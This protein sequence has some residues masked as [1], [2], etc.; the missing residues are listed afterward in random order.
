M[1]SLLDPVGPLPRS[2]YWR[3]RLIVLV[4]LALLVGGVVTLLNAIFSGGTPSASPTAAVTG[5]AAPV[6]NCDS[7]DIGLTAN[8]DK[9]SYVK[10]EKPMMSM[11]IT[12][13]GTTACTFQVGTDKQKYVIMSGADLI[14]DS[15]KCQTGATPYEQKFDPGQSVTTDAFAWGRT[16]S[17]NCTAGTPAV[18]GGASYQ[19]SVSIGDVT[20]E[21]TKQF[22]LF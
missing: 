15:T 21:K 2:V 5:T 20:S 10:G 1:S 8:T 19:L 16:R 13:N 7:K 14:W 18:A 6:T 22:M 17:D 9:D 12:N 3:R 11:T 4:I